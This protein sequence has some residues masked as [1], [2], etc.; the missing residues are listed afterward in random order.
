MSITIGKAWMNLEDEKMRISVT[1]DKAVFPLTITADKR[2]SLTPIPE[3]RKT[4]ENSPD[5]YVN[6]YVPEPKDK[7][8]SNDKQSKDTD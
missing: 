4:T 7:G 8:K 5:Y 2:L 1:L 6:L 3:D